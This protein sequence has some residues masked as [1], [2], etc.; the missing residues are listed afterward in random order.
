MRLAT[1]NIESLDIGPDR[2]AGTDAAF[3]ARVAVLRPILERLAADVLCLQEVNGQHVADAPERRLVALD[4][5]LQGTRYASYDRAA[6]TGPSG[7]GVASVHNLVTLSRFPILRQREVR[8]GHVAP[9]L[10]RFATG[11]AKG[12]EP[13]PVSF[14]RPLLIAEIGLPG[15]R[16]LTAINL[17][18]RAPRAS[19]VAGE[20]LDSVTWR[21]MGG[22]AEGYFLSSVK[23]TA[24]ALELRLVVDD[25]LA[26]DPE[27]LIAVAGDFNA[28]DRETPVRLAIGPEVETGDGEPAPQS[29]IVLDRAIATD[30]RWSALHRGRPL[31]PD[32]ILASRALWRHVQGIEVHNEGLNDEATTSGTGA[33]LG[34][35]HAP[36]V[37]ELDLR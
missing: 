8:H 20:K 10:H 23:R 29:L 12:G 13:Q 31:M 14:D 22:W 24:Q 21:T 30:R 28:E 34:S 37:A 2:G 4:R 18:L 36:L 27:C 3:E 1:F 9:L 16:R 25:M 35:L 26:Q 15:G 6:T 11:S 32:H 33:V 7:H 17:H 19:P 5:L